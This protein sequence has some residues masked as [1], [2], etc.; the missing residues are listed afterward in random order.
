LLSVLASQVKEKRV[1]TKTPSVRN[2]NYFF[3]F[4]PR[5]YLLILVRDGR[6]VVESRVKTFG[7]SYE[8][9]MRKWAEGADEI[10][11][12]DQT[13]KGSEFKY[14]I[15]R[16]EDVWNNLEEELRKI[17][18]F[19]GLPVD[20]FDFAAAANLPVRGS[21][22]FRGEE[23]H[24]HWKPVARTPAF[25][26]LK[27]ASHWNRSVHERFNWIAGQ[28]QATLGYGQANAEK[29]EFLSLLW[30]KAMDIRWQLI[31]LSQAMLTIAKNILKSMF[32]AE[33]M[34]KARRLVLGILKPVSN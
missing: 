23:K 3:K 24:I 31:E 17:L 18:T 28:Q 7:E 16:Y 30:N 14:L 11:R 19:V 29:R 12:F 27:R 33:R 25:D 15:V 9:A 2:L 20:S 34:S 13:A 4:F 10:L 6:A 1:V 22:V 26:P 32:G 5:A 21:S 8:A